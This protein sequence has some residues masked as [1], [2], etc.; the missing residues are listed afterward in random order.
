MAKAN[1]IR[2]AKSFAQEGDSLVLYDAAG[3]KLAQFERT[4]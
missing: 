3:I 4:S 2:L 1:E